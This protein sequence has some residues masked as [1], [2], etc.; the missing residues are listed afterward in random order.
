MVMVALAATLTLLP[1]VL[2]LLGPRVNLLPLP[3]F[4]RRRTQTDDANPNGF[5]EVTTRAVTRVPIISFVAVAAPMIVAIVF[6]FEINTG[7]STA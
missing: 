1:A 2:T 6:Y 5:W 7:R 4:G 3:Y